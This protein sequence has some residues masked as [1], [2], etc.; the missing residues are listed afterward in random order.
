MAEPQTSGHCYDRWAWMGMA[1]LA[2]LL[3]I[4]FR[5][6]DCL[7]WSSEIDGCEYLEASR[8]VWHYDS[9][10]HGP[11]YPLLIA[12][13]RLLLP[14][15]FS[16]AKLVSLLAG[17]AFVG[18]SWAVTRTLV[19]PQAA[20]VATLFLVANASVMNWSVRVTNHL[21]GAAFFIGTLAF[22]LVPRQPRWSH[23]LGA[24]LCLGWGYL[25]RQINLVLLPPLLVYLGWRASLS[26]RTRGRALVI[27][28]GTALIVCLPWLIRQQRLHGNPF[29]QANHL[30]IVQ[31]AYYNMQP[32]VWD[33]LLAQFPTLTSTLLY[34]PPRLLLAWADTLFDLPGQMVQMFGPAGLL[35]GAGFLLLLSRWDV[36][37]ELLMGASAL[38]A[39]V[40]CSVWL[41]FSYMLPLVPVAAL[42]LGVVF[43]SPLM[44]VR[45]P[46]QF[47]LRGVALAGLLLVCAAGTLKNVQHTLTERAY[48]YRT[49]GR[50][51]QS[52]SQPNEA[53]L[54]LVNMVAYYAH[55]PFVNAAPLL[56]R[57]EPEELAALLPQE[58]ARFFV[59]DE[60]FS[61]E[62]APC[63]RYLLDPTDPRVP[64][65]LRQVKTVEGP[66]RVV[67]YEILRPSQFLDSGALAPLKRP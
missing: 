44:P 2:V 14:D 63:Y 16:A 7:L 4:M 20:W 12:G 9:L 49:A 42:C 38:Y 33:E 36:R 55:R 5:L 39:L 26:R 64:A 18:L 48:E 46:G 30:D 61:P 15:E 40:L 28:L 22:V 35:L 59:W 23:W 32:V 52:V 17:L 11:G 41:Y 37:L 3:L 10:F 62:R 21:T 27:V 45:W 67:I 65:C 8:N 34:D 24:G 29:W 19:G 31:K 54:G 6:H 25:T 56:D 57:H 66:Y 53:I 47:P 43:T 13:A 58:E 51:L 1:A 60:R 50:Y